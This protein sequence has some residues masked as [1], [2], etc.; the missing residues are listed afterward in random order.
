MKSPNLPRDGTYGQL[1]DCSR[2][3]SLLLLTEDGEFNSFNQIS[4]SVVGI[5]YC[6]QKVMS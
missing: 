6:I 1:Y 5:L 2:P 3:A 4:W